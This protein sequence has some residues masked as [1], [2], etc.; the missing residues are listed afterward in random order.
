[1]NQQQRAGKHPS[2]SR[3]RKPFGLTRE[4]LARK[5]G[6]PKK[7][8]HVQL[9]G[10]LSCSQQE[11]PVQEDCKETRVDC[12]LKNIRHLRAEREDMGFLTFCEDFPPSSFLL[13]SLLHSVIFPGKNIIERCNNT[14]FISVVKTVFSAGDKSLQL[15]LQ[16][17][18][19]EWRCEVIIKLLEVWTPPMT[20]TDKVL[21]AA[22]LFEE[23]RL[24]RACIKHEVSGRLLCAAIVMAIERRNWVTLELFAE[25]GGDL[26]EVCAKC[27]MSL[28]ETVI[29]GRTILHDAI[30]QERKTMMQ[31]LN[32]G[33]SPD[34]PN[35][36]GE[37]P[38]HTAALYQEWDTLKLFL[39][40]TQNAGTAAS[41][42]T[43]YGRTLLHM[44]CECGQTEIVQTFLLM[45]ADPLLTDA[46]GNSLMVSALKATHGRENLMRV[47]I[48][49][50]MSTHQAVLSASQSG[51]SLTRWPRSPMWHA[52]KGGQ[53]RIAKMLY[54]SGATS[55]KEINKISS[56]AYIENGR[57]IRR[58]LDDISS[59]PRSLQDLCALTISHH[60][61]CGPDRSQRVARTG[62]P[63][64]LCRRVQH[65]HVLSHDFLSDMPPDPFPRLS[66]FFRRQR[67]DDFFP[68]LGEMP[69]RIGVVEYF[70]M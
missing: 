24:I 62:L 56:S 19:T 35:T 21:E 30:T 8:K 7:K 60:I 66:T 1:M 29:D 36:H 12:L 57:N 40:H 13:R 46:E 59:Q 14:T 65:E 52:V 6:S 17:A 32:A 64:A 53:L 70:D 38:L 58:F 26:S 67:L 68:I 9:L 23:W 61:G 2:F 27:T 45:G 5:L 44:L 47:L 28:N 33:A 43:A 4:K 41:R 39:Q 42:R 69:I 31:L 54:A 51:A 20:D 48:Q 11:Q 10:K 34:V 63:P 15:C 18:L 16:E 37:T 22:I 25:Q 3:D 55:H 50:G 49:S